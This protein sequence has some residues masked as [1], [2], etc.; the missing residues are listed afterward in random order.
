MF[1]ALPNNHDIVYECIHCKKHFDKNETLTRTC[2]YHP[3]IYPHSLSLRSL[4]THSC[5]GHMH[6]D[7][8]SSA[9][10]AIKDFWARYNPGQRF[11]PPGLLIAAPLGRS[12]IPWRLGASYCCCDVRA[13][14][15]GCKAREHDLWAKTHISPEPT[16]QEADNGQRDGQGTLEPQTIIGECKICHMSTTARS[17][18]TKCFYHPCKLRLRSCSAVNSL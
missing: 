14:I 9:F 17:L 7:I 6:V 11:G 4:L 13:D 8:H 5:K 10:G 16:L 1:A 15:L 2:R 12:R 18:S 3:G